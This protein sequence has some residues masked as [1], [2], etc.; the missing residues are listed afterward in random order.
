MKRKYLTGLLLGGAL[1][2]GPCPQAAVNVD[3]TRII[4][5]GNQ[6]SVSVVLSNESHDTPYLAQAWIEDADGKKINDLVALPPLQ[7]IDGGKKAQVRIMRANEALATRLPQDRESLFYFNVREI[8][9]EPPKT[10][11]NILQLTTQS[12]L[13]LLLRPAALGKSDEV[14]PERLLQILARGDSLVLKNPTP[15][16]VTVIWLGRD[17]KQ[18]LRGFD[19][20]PMLAPFSEQ[21]VKAALPADADEMVLGNVDDYGGLRMNRYRCAAGQCVFQERLRE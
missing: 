17:K 9:P 15:Y 6:K 13:K 12:R 16:Y 18:Q 2:W 21:E 14:N 5:G 4:M 11:A 7:R 3:R 8:P 1:A 10:D 19:G 20:A